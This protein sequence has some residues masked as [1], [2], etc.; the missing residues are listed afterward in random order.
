MTTESANK[1]ETRVNCGL[2]WEIIITEKINDWMENS[3]EPDFLYTKT[4]EN[5]VKGYFILSVK[6]SEWTK[7]DPASDRVAELNS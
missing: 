7:A 4:P 1:G 2:S 6:A 3:Y 5:F